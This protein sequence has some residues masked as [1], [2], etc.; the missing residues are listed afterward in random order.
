[1]RLSSQILACVLAASVVL[2]TTIPS[3]AQAQPAAK[4]KTVR[5]EL[6]GPARDAWDRALELFAAGKY[7]GAEAEFSQAY[8]LSKNPRTL[9]NVAMSIKAAPTPKYPKAVKILEQALAEGDGKLST[10]E[11]E[12]IL[13]EI[14]L[15]ADYVA[16]LNIEVNEPGA[17]ITVD[18]E[19]VGTSPLGKPVQVSSG[20]RAVAVS[21]TG[22]QTFTQTVTVSKTAPANLSVKLESLVRTTVLEVEVQGPVSA[23]VRIDGKEAGASPLKRK[24]EVKAEAL[25]VEAEAPGYEKTSQSIIVK[26]GEPAKITLLLARQQQQGRLSIAS[27]TPGASILID[28]QVVGADKWEGPVKTGYHTVQIKK[29]GYYPATYEVNV[30]ANEERR[31]NATLN[32]DRNNSFVPW[33]IGSLV[34]GVSA[35]VAGYFIFRPQD[36]EP[37]V[38]NLPPGTVNHSRYGGLRF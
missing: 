13:A 7:D 24:V 8:Q 6:S 25:V 30:G 18:G 32:E 15:L 21:K 1:M 34:V 2:P 3:V 5:D 38:G 36:Q 20:S 9:F 31:V 22:F 14:K 29:Q 10:Q 35:T 19:N 4:A 23:T 17:T 27:A 12:R 11:R 33:L 26:E 37:V 28:S 16:S